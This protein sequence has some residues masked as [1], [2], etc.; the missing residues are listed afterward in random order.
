M[1]ED[2]SII[3]TI[4]YRQ[5]WM[6]ENAIT[7]PGFLKAMGIR[8][9]NN[10]EQVPAFNYENQCGC[11][12]VMKVKVRVAARRAWCAETSGNN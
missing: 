8:S 12:I 5:G 7:D 11:N 4:L 9:Q 2:F 1:R 10:R 6:I 3:E